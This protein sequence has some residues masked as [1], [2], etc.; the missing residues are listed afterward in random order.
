[1]YKIKDYI[2]KNYNE[3]NRLLS[4]ADKSRTGKLSEEEFSGALI[5]IYPKIAKDHIKQFIKAADIDKDGKIDYEEFIT[6]VFDYEIK[7]QVASVPQAKNVFIPVI[8]HEVEL[9]D[10]DFFR[11]QNPKC[12]TILNSQEAAIKQCKILLSKCNGKFIDT[13]FGPEVG[14]NGNTCLY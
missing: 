12:T 10:A 11:K 1:M 3:I 13:E 4:E 8:E 2:K 9:T 6:Y 14:K 5:K 7:Q